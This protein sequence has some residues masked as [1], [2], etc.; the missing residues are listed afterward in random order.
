[1]LKLLRHSLTE[2]Q[3]SE[4]SEVARA[5]KCLELYLEGLKLGKDLPKTELQPADDLII[6]YAQIL[7]NAWKISDDEMHLY[8][9]AVGLEVAL[10]HSQQAYQI[11]LTLIRI[12]HLLG[13]FP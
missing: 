3:V 8:K 11:R 10:T 12:Y 5:D 7:V 1:V 9:A 6:L 2:A 4:E 13:G